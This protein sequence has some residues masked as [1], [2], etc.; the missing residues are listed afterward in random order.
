MTIYTVLSNY[1]DDGLFGSYT[2]ILRARKA[3]EYYFTEANDIV[4]FEDVGDYVYQFTTDKGETFSAAIL[5][6]M[7]DWEFVRGEIREDNQSF[8]IT[9]QSLHS[10]NLTSTPFHAIIYSRKRK[11]IKHYGLHLPVLRHRT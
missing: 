1:F 10:F 2:S 4:S 7:L 6:D 8:L 3:I 9:R 11:G 5:S